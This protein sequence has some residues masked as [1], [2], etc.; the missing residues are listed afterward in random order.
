LPSTSHRTRGRDRLVGEAVHRQ[1]FVDLV[2]VLDGTRS[3]Q[4]WRRGHL[5]DG[6]VV[7]AADAGHL[8]IGEAADVVDHVE[9]ACKRLVGDLV[10]AGLD[11]PD[12][13]ARGR[14]QR[15]DR[16]V[17]PIQLLFGREHV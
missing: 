5:R 9:P 10:V 8:G 11:R 7:F 1:R 4:I 16:G 2:H 3:L 13:V 17:E 15:L 6:R 14:L 12:G